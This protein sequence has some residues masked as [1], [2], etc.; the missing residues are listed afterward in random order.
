VSY[1]DG[2]HGMPTTTADEVRDYTR[3]ILD[4]YDAHLKKP[5]GP[6]SE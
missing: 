5:A 6:P 2:G 3:R 1:I 4:W